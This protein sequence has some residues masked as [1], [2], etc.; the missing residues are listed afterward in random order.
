VTWTPDHDLAAPDFDPPFCPLRTKQRHEEF[1]L[2]VALQA[3][4]TEH[5]TLAQVEA[6]AAQL[7]PNTEVGDLERDFVG[8]C[9]FAFGKEPVKSTAKHHRNDVAV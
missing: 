9:E 5:F 6:H 4:H 3:G 1:A 2:A 8:G 7:M